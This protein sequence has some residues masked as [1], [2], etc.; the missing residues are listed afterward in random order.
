[1]AEE[2]KLQ[3]KAQQKNVHKDQGEATGCRAI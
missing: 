3:E 2:E 1:M